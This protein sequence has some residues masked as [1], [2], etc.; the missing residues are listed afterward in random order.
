MG[1]QILKT[2]QKVSDACG[3]K[4]TYLSK[5]S[6]RYGFSYE[7]ADSL[8]GFVLTGDIRLFDEHNFIQE[9][10]ENRWFA[11]NSVENIV[12]DS[13]DV[14]L[15][16]MANYKAPLA[17]GEV[18]PQGRLKYIDGA[19]NSLLMSPPKKGD[20]CL[21]ALYM[22]GKIDQTPHTHPSTRI[23]FILR[24]QVTV[25]IWDKEGEDATITDELLL[26]KGDAWFMDKDTIHSFHTEASDDMCLFAF[27]P[28]SD[29]GPTDE[30]APM[31]NR[32]IIEGVSSRGENEPAKVKA[33]RL[34]QAC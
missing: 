30:E 21:N 22:A 2:Q 14:L 18:E 16:E 23:G 24:G 13:A 4:A 32:T 17:T 9:I 25:R 31:I 11:A 20:P 34:N 1:F 28:D 19:F 3:V 8:F 5:L 27:H 12:V 10:T 29:F 7:H 33:S 26:K 15:I 6:H